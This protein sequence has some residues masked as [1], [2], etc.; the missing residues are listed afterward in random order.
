[1]RYKKIV[2]GMLVAVMIAGSLQG[3]VIVKASETTGYSEAAEV[4]V[5]ESD[6]QFD[7]TTGTITKYTGTEEV[8]VIPSTIGGTAVKI[9]GADCF[10]SNENIISVEIPE[11]VSTIE[12]EAF[13]NCPNL[14]TVVIPKGVESL[15]QLAF[16]M[17][18]KLEN[19]IM[20]SGIT[21]IETNTF[22]G[23]ASLKAIQLPDTVTKIGNYAFMGCSALETMTIPESTTTIGTGAF[24]NC[25]GLKEIT[26]PSSVTTMEEEV[27]DRETNTKI[28]CEA[29]SKAY[30]YAHAYGIANSVDEADVP[31]A[32]AA[33]TKAVTT[34]PT[35][36]AT[37]TPTASAQKQT[38]SIKYVLK[39]GKI[40][41]TSVKS[42]DGTANITLPKATRKGYTFAGWYTESSYK[43]KVTAI[44][45]GTT[46]NKTF[47]AKWKKVSK[48]SKPSISALKNSRSKQLSIKLKKKISGAKGY[49]MAYARNKKFTKSK[50]TVRFTGIAKTVKGLKKGKTYYVKVRAYKLD[51][52]N[53]RVYGSYSSVKKVTIKK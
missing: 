41:G 22:Y 35:K 50:K 13:L 24:Q 26:I 19:V 16:F 27:F 42:Y 5:S 15:G 40:S 21:A 20:G 12:E 11:G 25:M 10:A 17:C 34:A 43:K 2:S 39:G 28:N 30:E 44:K 46:G 36:A 14:Q 9:I 47:Y 8:V 23:C 31:T 51:S 33:P 45:K 38:Y 48:P 53:K 32:T 1:M 29:G 6:F 49:E 37:A 3:S 4:N 7:A 52:A 18:E